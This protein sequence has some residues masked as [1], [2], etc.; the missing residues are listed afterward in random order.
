M[1]TNVYDMDHQISMERARLENSGLSSDVQKSI[2]GFVNH[3]SSKQVTKHRQYFYSV[4]LRLIAERMGNQFLEPDIETVE[5]L[6][7]NLQNGESAR[8][9]P[10]TANTINDFKVA[11]KRF[12]MWKFR[13]RE[14]MID[15]LDILKK[16]GSGSANKKSEDIITQ[17][18]VRELIAACEHNSRDQLLISMLYDSG[19]RISELLTMR[20]KD[21]V[22]DQYG[23][24]IHV[25]GKTGER[26]VRL[27][28][29]SQVYFKNWILRH[30][31]R[32]NPDAWLYIKLDSG[33][34][35][36]DKHEGMDYYTAQKVLRDAKRRS[37]ITKRIHLHQFRHTRATLLARDLKE[38]PL[39]RQMGWIHGSRQTRTYVHLKDKDVDI[40][41]LKAYGIEVQEEKYKHIDDLPRVCPRCGTINTSDADYCK[42]CALPIEAN[43]VIELDKKMKEA[44]STI[45]D[46]SFV[47]ERLKQLLDDPNFKDKVVETILTMVTDSSQTKEKFVKE[48]REKMNKKS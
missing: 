45:K 35:R 32:E 3:V 26:N 9:G 31:D 12:Y 10:Y 15:V 4:R 34:Y 36:N 2:I 46:S 37:G 28:G 40:A 29:D 16:S 1:D 7:N 8:H 25:T 18:E 19:C 14:G 47:S 5:E 42:R 23:L 20:I 38:A 30:P 43:K 6:I 22:S 11:L 39:E 48:A 44:E 24:Y 21:V 27:V 17:K 41:V 13:N 33:K